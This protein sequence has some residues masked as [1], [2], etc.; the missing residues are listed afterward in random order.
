MQGEIFCLVSDCRLYGMSQ[1]F[2]GSGV[3]LVRGDAVHRAA[4][5]DPAVLAHEQERII[6]RA[7]H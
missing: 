6:R 4:N 3:A 1:E 7:R 5:I 2:S